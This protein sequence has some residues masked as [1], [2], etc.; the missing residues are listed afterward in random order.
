MMRR[1]RCGNCRR[2][3]LV[4]GTVPLES[5]VTAHMP[6]IF[7]PACPHASPKRESL[8]GLFSILMMILVSVVASL[9]I[10]L[11][12]VFHYSIMVCILCALQ[13]SRNIK[14]WNIQ[15]DR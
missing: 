1:V 14:Q 6:S 8:H 10:N 2:D 7:I 3:P 15:T 12:Y 13:A 9:Y 11:Q 4:G 5:Q